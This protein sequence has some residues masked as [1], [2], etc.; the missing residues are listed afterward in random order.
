M[1]ERE[2]LIREGTLDDLDEIFCLYNNYMFDSYL[3]KFG[4]SFVKK[5]LKVIIKSKNCVTLVAAENHIAGFIMATFNSN[6]ILPELFFNIEILRAWIK[7]VLVHPSLAFESLKS[8][9][10]PLITAS[11]NV[12]A[13]FLFIAIE[14][15][16]RKRNLATELIK[17]V[18]SLM[19]QRGIRKV[20]VTTLV[21]N[22][23]V[24]SLLE[25]LGFEAEKTFRL[26]NKYMYLYTYKL[27]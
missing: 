14:P 27:Y 12:N 3:L 10:Y 18:L 23:A 1:A 9:L 17:E 4:S 24:N 25:K 16:Y 20:K 8:I 5:Y 22:E 21:K 19:R 2:I 11:K 15:I 26:C 13:E 7:Q 6:K